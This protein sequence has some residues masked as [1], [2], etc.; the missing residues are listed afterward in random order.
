[1]FNIIIYFEIRYYSIIPVPMIVVMYTSPISNALVS[2]PWNLFFRQVSQ[3]RK[4]HISLWESIFNF[5]CSL[6]SNRSNLLL[7]RFIFSW[8]LLDSRWYLFSCR[9]LWLFCFSNFRRSTS[10]SCFSES[11]FHSI[12]RYYYFVTERIIITDKMLSLPNFVIE[13]IIVLGFEIFLNILACA[14]IKI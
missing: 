2:I 10:L 4:G 8:W 13:H 11:M 3:F 1:M 9:F 12:L 6:D 7:R 5:N 14:W